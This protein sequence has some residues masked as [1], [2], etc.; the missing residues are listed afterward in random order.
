MRRVLLLVVLVSAAISSCGATLRLRATAPTADNDGSCG[1]PALFAAPAGAPRVV[2]F[3]WSGP[4]AGEDSVSTTAGTLVS[5]VRTVPP[6]TYTVR[7]WA[8]DAGGA[9]CDTTLTVTVKAAPWRV[10]FQ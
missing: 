2:H 3:Q 10:A 5:I 7:G 9:G 4:A 1:A 6:G 8:S